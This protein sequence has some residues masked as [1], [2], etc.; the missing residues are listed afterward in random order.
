MVSSADI[1]A[2]FREVTRRCTFEKGE[3][4]PGRAW[5][6]GAAHWVTDLGEGGE[7]P[8]AGVAAREPFRLVCEHF[9]AAGYPTQLS[10]ASGICL[11]KS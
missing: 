4:L 8:R 6:A 2:A 5:D 10:K 3:G 7:V 1:L 9:Q 11:A